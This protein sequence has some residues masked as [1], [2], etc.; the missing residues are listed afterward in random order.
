MEDVLSARMHAHPFT[1]PMTSLDYV[2]ARWYQPLS[3]T[4]LT[5]DPAGYKDSANLYSFAGGDPVNGRDPS[6][7]ITL[8]AALTDARLT[9]YEIETIELT[10]QETSAIIK[11]AHL[12]VE[13]GANAKQ[14]NRKR[15]QYVL[16]LRRPQFQQLVR[17]QYEFLRGLN[18]THYE[19]EAINAIITGREPVTGERVS[20]AD[21][22]VQLLAYMAVTQGMQYALG[23]LRAGALPPKMATAKKPPLVIGEAMDD[24]VIPY[25][26]SIG[27]EYYRGAGRNVPV[28]SWLEHNRQ[29]IRNAMNEGREIIDI[30][31]NPSR[32]SWPGPTSPN[33]AMELEEVARA[34]YQHYVRRLIDEPTSLTSPGGHPSLPGDRSGGVAGG[35]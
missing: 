20:R 29:M 5:P 18:P 11:S 30:G 9:D 13:T 26:N 16:I 3:G 6:G 12:R 24:R 27:G 22:A 28:E 1:E 4:W 34:N 7:E 31:P 32:R 19:G 14:T 10:D 35:H 2:R 33:Y 21:K 23:Q 17:E 25:A 8:K 15:A